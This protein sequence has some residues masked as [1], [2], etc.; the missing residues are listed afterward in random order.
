LL[1]LIV[2]LNFAVILQLIAVQALVAYYR[3][4]AHVTI[5]CCVSGYRTFSTPWLC[6]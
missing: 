3:L 6:C 5:C 2:A 1:F 4:S